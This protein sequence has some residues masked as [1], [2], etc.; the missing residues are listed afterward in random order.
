MITSIDHQLHIL[1]IDP[2]TRISSLL[3]GIQNQNHQWPIRKKNVTYL[4]TWPKTAGAACAPLGLA[5]GYLGSLIKFLS[6][7]TRNILL[8]SFFNCLLVYGLEHLMHV[9]TLLELSVTSMYSQKHS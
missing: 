4:I 6:Y 8:F 9:Q 1:C 7:Y 3:P 5:C 2:Q